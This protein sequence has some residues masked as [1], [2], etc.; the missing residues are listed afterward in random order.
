MCPLAKN[1]EPEVKQEELP[2]EPPKE[3]SEKEN[4]QINKTTIHCLPATVNFKEDYLYGEVKKVIKYGEKFKFDAVLLG[5]SDFQISF[6]TNVKLSNESVI[7]IF[8]LLDCL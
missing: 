6:W 1:A 3:T 8:F 2:E 7:L 4:P 5:I